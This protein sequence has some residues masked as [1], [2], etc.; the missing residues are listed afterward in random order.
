V[1]ELERRGLRQMKIEKN[2]MTTM[3]TRRMKRKVL[4]VMGIQG[5]LHV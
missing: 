5:S 2:V 3:M 1:S 4:L